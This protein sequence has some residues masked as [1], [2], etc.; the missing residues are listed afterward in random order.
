M[1]FDK[2]KF[3]FVSFSGFYLVQKLP[4]FEQEKFGN[5]QKTG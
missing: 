3:L 2:K 5:F 1:F 4:V